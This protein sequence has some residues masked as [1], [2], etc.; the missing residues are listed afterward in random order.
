MVI[1][2][3]DR[4]RIEHNHERFAGAGHALAS[5]PDVAARHTEEPA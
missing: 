4:D 3:Y 5:P 2:L 1:R